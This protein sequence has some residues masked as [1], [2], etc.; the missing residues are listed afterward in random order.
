MDSGN[1]VGVSMGLLFGLVGFLLYRLGRMRV[2]EAGIL[3]NLAQSR[4]M[5]SELAQ[6]VPVGICH[7]DE[8]GFCTFLMIAIWH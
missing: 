6:L 7:F 4:M 8:R 1:V 5:F 3:T 2:R